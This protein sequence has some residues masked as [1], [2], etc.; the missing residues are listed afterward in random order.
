MNAPAR[1]EAA[2]ATAC[3][4]PPATAGSRPLAILRLRAWA[5]AR[6]W[7]AGELDLHEAI[8]TLQAAAVR[9]GLI[10]KLGQDCVQAIIAAAFA[11]VRDDFLK[12]EDIEAEPTLADDAWSA[13][14][15]RDA[16]VAYHNRGNRVSVTSYTA[17]ELA[18]LRG[19]MADDVTL[20]RA[21]HE[22]NHPADRATASTVEALMF[23]L[24]RGINELTQ[25]STL[26]RLSTLDEH[27]LED[28]CL[29]VQAFQRRIA[30]A[31]SAADVHLLI[32]AWRKFRGQP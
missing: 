19:L 11:A 25:R 24:R 13:P 1:V 22:I 8:D 2:T 5:R 18:R 28:L 23:S 7:Q 6:L 29:R 27:Q 9:D 15:W 4:Q 17:D 31:W 14:G 30:P 16:A 20:E 26:R 10:A 32:S 12:S 3:W 21:W